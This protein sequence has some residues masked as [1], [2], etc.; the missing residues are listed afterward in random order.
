MAKHITQKLIK[1]QEFTNSG[2]SQ[3]PTPVTDRISRKTIHKDTEERNRQKIFWDI[4][5]YLRTLKRTRIT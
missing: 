5:R 3:Q 4:K 2:R 1:L